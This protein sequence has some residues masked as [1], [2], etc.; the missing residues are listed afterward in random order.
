MSW[1]SYNW[2]CGFACLEMV[3]RALG[4]PPHECSLRAMRARVPSSSIWCAAIPRRPRPTAP[5]PPALVRA[6]H[7]TV[8]LVYLLREYGTHFRFLTTTLGVNPDYKHEEFY[9][10]TLDADSLRVSELFSSSCSDSSSC[11][12]SSATHPC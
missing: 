11:I 6:R 12:S 1:Q 3:L 2:D 4:V 9:R 10:P 8:D 5:A 7:R